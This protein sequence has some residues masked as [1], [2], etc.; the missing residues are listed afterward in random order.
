M[1]DI[2]DA[3]ASDAAQQIVQALVAGM[4]EAVKRIPRLW[5]RSGP[6]KEEQIEAEIKRTV[7]LLRDP[8]NLPAVV[9]R[10]EG[11]WEARLR[12]LLDEYPETTTEL[13]QILDE[14]RNQARVST[15]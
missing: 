9:S 6:S 2:G 13:R 11:A 10:Q 5:R 14:I 3:L 4:I 7:A 1:T 12:D 8:E 15:C